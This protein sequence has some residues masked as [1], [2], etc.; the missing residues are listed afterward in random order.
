MRIGDK[1]WHAKRIQ[2]NN[3]EI[4]SYNE[5]IEITTRCN[6]LTVMQASSRG[7]MEV[8]KYGEKLNNTWTVIANAKYFDGEFNI[9]DV[10]WVDGESPI[11]EIEQEYGYGASATAIVKSVV[12]V[13]KTISI[14]LERNQKQ[15]KQ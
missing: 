3:V 7:Y 5:P 9:G 1:V 15:T 11:D 14:T 13:N 12:P 10:M 2:D 8:V 6:Y 4:S